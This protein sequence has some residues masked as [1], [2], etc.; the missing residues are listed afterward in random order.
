MGV[1]VLET[2]EAPENTHTGSR[3]SSPKKVAGLIAQLKC[4]Y[5]NGK[6]KLQFKQ[7]WKNGG[8]TCAS[9]MLQQVAI[10]YAESAGKESPL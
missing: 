7:S 9:G 10:N 6:Q 8:M 1:G 4:I 3:S 5:T 2:I